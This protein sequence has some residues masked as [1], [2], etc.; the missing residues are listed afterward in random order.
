MTIY[1]ATCILLLVGRACRERQ[2]G[3]YFSECRDER[4]LRI[5]A[6][7]HADRG[8]LAT[9]LVPLRLDIVYMDDTKRFPLPDKSF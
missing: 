2:I 7:K 1:V 3:R 9:D 4:Y 8:W 6:G 5:G